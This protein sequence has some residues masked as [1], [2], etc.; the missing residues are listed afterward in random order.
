MI[1]GDAAAVIPALKTTYE[2][3]THSPAH[4]VLTLFIDVL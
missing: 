1:L 4:S 2:I 3:R